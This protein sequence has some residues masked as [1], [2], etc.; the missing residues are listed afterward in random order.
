MTKTEIN[1]A[2]IKTLLT[3]FN[4]VSDRKVKRFADLASA[5]KRCLPLATAEKKAPASSRNVYGDEMMIT[6][7]SAERAAKMH[8]NSRRAKSFALVGKGVTVEKFIA[9]G[10]HRLDLSK[11]VELGIVAV[12]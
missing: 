6:V 7:A 1:N 2:S 4:S 12:A 5:R 11:M 8:E 3:F 9:K 10:G